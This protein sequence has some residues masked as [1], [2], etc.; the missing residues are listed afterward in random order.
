MTDIDNDSS[1]IEIKK[2]L[3]GYRDDKTLD[4]RLIK[5][6]YGYVY[7]MKEYGGDYDLPLAFK[8]FDQ[9]KAMLSK[10]VEYYAPEP[11]SLK[12]GSTYNDIDY[13]QGYLKALRELGKEGHASETALNLERA[14]L[15]KDPYSEPNSHPSAADAADTNDLDDEADLYESQNVNDGKYDEGGS[16]EDEHN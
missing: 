8:F 15:S 13:V 9:S 11:N 7:T 10:Y 3:V 14:Y 4:I 2:H 12:D 5:W 1:D 16:A 6:I